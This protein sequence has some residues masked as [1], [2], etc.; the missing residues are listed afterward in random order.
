MATG[1][2][3]LSEMLESVW[4]EA[5]SNAVYGVIIVI[6][7][8]VLFYFTKFLESMA[9]VYILGRC[10][11]VLI[12]LVGAATLLLALQRTVKARQV[13]KS[14]YT[15]PY[16]DG[17]NHL[18]TVPTED[19]DCEHCHRTIHFVDGQ[20]IPVRTVVCQFCRTEHRVAANVQRYVCDRCNRLLQLGAEKTRKLDMA[21]TTSVAVDGLQQNYDVLLVA[22]DKRH[23]N[24]LAF[25]IQNLLVV[26]LNEARRLLT[27]VSNQNP[28][29]VTMDVPQRKAEAVRRQL[30]EL[31]A[32]AI[33]RP[34]TAVR[35][36]ARR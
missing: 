12:M 9:V 32:T 33:T 5:I 11:S 34:T 15:C 36:P 31:G 27:T 25:K 6:V 29:V 14:A 16:C 26:N 35:Q 4:A 24:D 3:K 20:Q 13:G 21:G 1:V 2:T 7:G 18:L 30:Q 22:I 10:L 8:A 17:E 23:E 28:L 19:F